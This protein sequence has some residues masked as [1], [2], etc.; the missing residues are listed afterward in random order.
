MHTAD[1]YR[2]VA[3]CSHGVCEGWNGGTQNVAV[4]PD[5]VL[6]RIT[7]AEHR[8]SRWHAYW[9]RTVNIVEDNAL[10][11]KTVDMGSADNRIP[12]TTRN[13]WTVLV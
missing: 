13:V 4:S 5:V 1:E 9:R 6:K 10:G 12:V 8:H 11:S 2:S 3:R 7:P